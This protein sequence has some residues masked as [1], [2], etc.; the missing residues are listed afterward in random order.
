MLKELEVEKNGETQIIIT[1]RIYKESIQIFN[2]KVYDSFLKDDWVTVHELSDDNYEKLQN[3]V[4]ESL[5]I[6]NKEK[7]WKDGFND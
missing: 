6:F 3:Y 4:R 1:Y 5:N 7:E 2:Y